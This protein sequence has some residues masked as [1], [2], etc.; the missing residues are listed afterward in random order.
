MP[1]GGCCRL[2]GQANGG[3]RGEARSEDSQSQSQASIHVPDGLVSHALPVADDGGVS[4]R[5]L[6]PFYAKA[7]EFELVIILY[8]LC[9]KSYSEQLELPS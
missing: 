3:L 8:V 1:S 5:G 7:G 6:R 2:P 9:S 4:L